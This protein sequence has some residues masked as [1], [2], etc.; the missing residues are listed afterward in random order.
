MKPPGEPDDFIDKMADIALIF[1]GLNFAFFADAH[2]LFAVLLF[3]TFK[4][5]AA[6]KNQREKINEDLQN[7]IILY[8]GLLLNT[9]FSLGICF[10]LRLTLFKGMVCA[11]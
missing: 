10:D 11:L 9:G 8:G 6:L 7:K 2:W 3:I 4:K 1:E 5:L